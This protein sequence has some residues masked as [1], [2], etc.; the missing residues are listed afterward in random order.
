MAGP[1]SAATEFAP[2]GN[3]MKLSRRDVTTGGLSLLAA[4]SLSSVAQAKTVSVNE[5]VSAAIDAYIYG[6]PLMIM[7]MTRRQLTNVGSSGSSR[8]PMGQLV[9]RRSYPAVDDHTVPAPNADTLYTNVWLDVTKEP[10]VLSIPDMGNRYFMMPM[11]S[12]WTEVF[13]APGSR[14][15]G[16]KPQNYVI[17]GPGWSGKLPDGLTEYKSPTGLV[18][19]LGRIY[20][21][22]TAEDYAEVH[23]L[24]D[25]FAIVP[26]SYFGKPYTPPPGEV[27]AK[28]D[29]KTGAREQ[30]N[31]LGVNDYFN[32]LATLLRTNPPVAADNSI[33][34]R[35][36][37][38]GL[39]PGQ[40][41]DASK[42]TKPQQQ[43]IKA[44]PK[45]AQL[46][47]LKRFKEMHTI[48]GWL[49]FGPSVAKWGTDY[50]LRGLCNM[51]GPGWNLPQDAVYPAAEKDANGKTLDGRK[52]YVIHFDKGQ[53]PPVK[54]FWSLTMY[55]ENRF[56]VPNSLN[57]YTLSQRNNF[58]ANA[59]GSVDLY[60]R[61]NSPGRD[62]EPN[63]LP[64]PEGKFSVMLRLYWPNE[65]SPSI[66]DGTWKPPVITAIG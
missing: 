61:A 27:D 8:A 58:V 18:W 59:D 38:I 28:L 26:I 57:R 49:D 16:G 64:A 50:L 6:Y 63:W 1:K 24:Q 14:T 5:A 23:A 3:L 36:S 35:M 65:N 54:G 33:V 10:W 55:D 29:M 44:V 4:T 43:A 25:K 39:V 62:K 22:G 11:L 17:T 48:N 21:T 51:L 20:C 53:M 52:N 40:A 56:F 12:G 31:S 34:E 60:L 46:R 7:D 13:Q 66:V 15:T 9:R 41:F 47:M 19:I 32:Y 37:V 42:L 2:E 30:I 45:L